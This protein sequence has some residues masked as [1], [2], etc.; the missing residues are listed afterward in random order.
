MILQPAYAASR[1]LRWPGLSVALSLALFAVVLGWAF[2]PGLFSSADPLLAD[3]TQTLQA[4]SVRH[5]FGTDHLG[6]DLYARS[7]HGAALSLQATS[8]AVLI[9]LVAG[10]L[11]GGIAGWFGGVADRVLAV[12][13]EVLMAIPALLLAMAIVTALGFGTLEIALA[14]GLSSVAIF[15]R[16]ARGEVLR[17]RSR[18]FVEAARV[19]GVGS[20]TNLWRHV[21]P[22]AAGPLLALAALEFASAVLAVSA[23]SFLGFGAP[24]PQPEWGLLI[25]EGRNYMVVAW[26]YTTLPGLVVATVVLATQQL[27]RGLQRLQGEAS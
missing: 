6:R 21:L 5:W 16:L 4:P 26:W 11:L 15:A 22:H 9:A 18:T 19:A 12:I 23:L 25:A 7:V 24:P 10:S 17:W 8:I 13:V 3:P 1:P 14:V 27:A 20:W 2:W